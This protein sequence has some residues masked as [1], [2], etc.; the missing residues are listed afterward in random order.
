[1]SS[2]FFCGYYRAILGIYGDNGKEHGNYRDYRVI[3]YFIW[4][5]YGTPTMENQMEK[6]MDNE[7]ET[8]VI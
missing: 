2:I 1:M 5:Y 4:G 6:K 8:V 3:L 7:M